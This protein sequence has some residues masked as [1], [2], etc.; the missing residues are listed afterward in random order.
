G[1][2]ASASHGWRNRLTEVIGG[3]PLLSEDRVG[4]EEASE[5]LHMAHR[6][7]EQAEAVL[8][9]LLMVSRTERGMT[10]TAPA[11]TDLAETV[12]NVIATFES[13]RSEEH[14]SEL[15]SRENLVCRLLLEKN[16]SYELA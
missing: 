3:P 9:D 6:E 10:Q 13:S 7:A 1:T 12:R 15:Q 4:G 11:R 8:D 14:T 5:L 16:K 2:R